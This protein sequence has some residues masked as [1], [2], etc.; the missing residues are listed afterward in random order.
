MTRTRT[1]NRGSAEGHGEAL[2]RI[3]EAKRAGAETLDLSALGLSQIPEE[4]LELRQLKE[5]NLGANS[6]GPEGLNVL[7]YLTSLVKLCLIWNGAGD[8]G[9]LALSSLAG[10]R[11][12]DLRHNALSTRGAQALAKLV[13][14]TSLSVTTHFIPGEHNCYH[15]NRIGDEG[16]QALSTL[17]NLAELSIGGNGI[18]DVGAGGLSCLV[19]LTSLDI[20]NNEVSDAGVEALSNLF[21]LTEITLS[22]NSVGDASVES[23][24]KLVKLVS[25]DLSDTQV[26]TLLPLARLNHLERLSCAM[27]ELDDPGPAFWMKPS[28]KMVEVTDLSGVPQEILC[29]DFDEADADGYDG[30]LERL[31]KH[32][33]CHANTT[34]T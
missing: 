26:K 12:L 11:S 7:T 20:A 9:A 27:C 6:I 10:L 24:T 23:L 3:E 15:P 31:R 25:L 32:F 17:V 22:G 19:N 30:C 33:A 14:L 5:L 8:R 13:N 34:R 18:S 29:Q 4:L 21:R 1:Y 28:L 16:A 2:R